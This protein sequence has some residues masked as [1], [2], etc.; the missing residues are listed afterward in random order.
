MPRPRKFE[1][2]DK[3]RIAPPRWEGHYPPWVRV[4]RVIT[5]QAVRAAQRHGKCYY[6][7]GSRWYRSDDLRRTDE[8][9]LR[10]TNRFTGAMKRRIFERDQYRCAYCGATATVVDHIDPRSNG[11]K[12]IESNGVAACAS[13]NSKKGAHLDMNMLARGFFVAGGHIPPGPLQAPPAFS[14]LIPRTIERT[15]DDEPYS[16]VLGVDNNKPKREPPYTGPRYGYSTGGRIYHQIVSYTKFGWPVAACTLELHNNR[17]RYLPK[18]G[19]IPSYLSEP[20][21]DAAPC[22]H[23]F[24]QYWEG[25][26]PDPSSQKT[27]WTRIATA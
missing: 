21:H 1:V 24:P 5:I 12:A 16:P 11:G 20:P 7:S 23:C 4:G 15:L 18:N 2:G 3:A 25:S 6:R 27:V 10:H 22:R 14:G 19:R 9:D 8:A 26:Q 17:P 13:C